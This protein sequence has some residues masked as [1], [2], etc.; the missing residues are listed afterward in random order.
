MEN[1]Y[2]KRREKALII[3]YVGELTINVVSELK[4]RIYPELADPALAAIVVDLSEVEFLDSSGIGFLIALRSKVR[5]SSKLFFL[6]HPS[7][8]VRKTLELVKLVNF[9]ETLEDEDELTLH[10]AG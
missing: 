3:Q 7:Q 1:V 6:L 9:F 4:E 5:N 10:L 2:L 8:P